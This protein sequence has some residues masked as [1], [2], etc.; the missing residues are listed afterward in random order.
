M[1]YDSNKRLTAVAERGGIGP[2]GRIIKGVQR[3]V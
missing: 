2:P 3:K 1:H